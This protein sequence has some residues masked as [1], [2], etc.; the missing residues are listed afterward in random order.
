MPTNRKNLGI[1][2]IL[3]GLLLIILILYFSF[4]QSA[5]TVAP[6]V[7]VATTTAQLPTSTTGTTTPSDKPQGHQTYNL[8]QEPAHQ[9]NAD[10]LSKIAMAF[11]ERFG[12]FSNQSGYSNI[13]DLQ[14][15]MTATMRTWAA[16]YIQQLTSQY[17]NNGAFYGITTHALI[18][19]VNAF[20]DK[21]GKAAI[22]ITTQRT[23]SG[24]SQPYNQKLDLNF[25][26][27]DGDW[28]VDSAHWEK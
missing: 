9:T 23:V 18:A 14:I 11:A 13:T 3:L 12:S 26:K 2:L 19:Q 20:D 27:V 21:A 24:Q 4:R 7:P 25:L 22:T 28:L 1:L 10:D 15:S 16:A 5:T 8:A 17:K 6:A